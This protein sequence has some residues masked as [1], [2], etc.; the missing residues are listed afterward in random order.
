MQTQ[1]GELPASRI[2][3]LE[4]DTGGDQNDA[5][6]PRSPCLIPIITIDSPPR[7]N[8][9]RKRSMDSESTRQGEPDI[10]QELIDVDALSDTPSKVLPFNTI[11]YDSSHGSA[12]ARQSGL[13]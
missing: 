9:T 4:D 12:R 11:K 7:T 6:N 5:M 8:N 1:I 10:K 13:N 2:I 3:N